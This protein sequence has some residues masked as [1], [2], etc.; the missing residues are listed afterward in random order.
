M[1]VS[2]ANDGNTTK[3][4]FLFSAKTIYTLDS[5]TKVKRPKRAL[6]ALM[7]MLKLGI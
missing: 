7:P 1:H 2:E 4:T 3:Q 5:Q 6:A